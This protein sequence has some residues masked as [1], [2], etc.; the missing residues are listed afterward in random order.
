MERRVKYSKI[1]LILFL[2][3]FIWI[4]LQF[5]APFFLPENSVT[6]LSGLVGVS[7]NDFQISNMSFPWNVIY[8]AGDGLCHQIAERSFV[9]NGNQMP[10]CS[11]CTA[12]WLGLAIG[13]GFMVFYRIN[14]DEKFIF[15]ILITI[16][17]MGIDGVGQLLHF[18]ESSN[19][20]RVTTGLLAG[21]LCGIVIAIIIDEAKELKK[22]KI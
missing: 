14:L 3:F 9:L 13:L 18:W 4:I 5:L 16:A 20:I 1:T 17:P 8:R 11:R 12:I 22:V 19:I 6:D 2:F 7:D 21:G 15:V 10:F